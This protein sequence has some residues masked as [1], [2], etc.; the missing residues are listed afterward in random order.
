MPGTSV[1]RLAQVILVIYGLLPGAAYAADT[2][3]GQVLVGGAPVAKSEVT[4]WEANAST[5]KKLA[6][7]RASDDGRFEVRANDVHGDSVIYLTASGG[8]GRQGWRRQCGHHAA[9]RAQR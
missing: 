9:H 7:A 3:K 8:E 1:R 4:L 6:E 2:I 5:P